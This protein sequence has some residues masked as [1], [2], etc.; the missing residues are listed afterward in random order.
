MWKEW[1]QIP[2][3]LN[4]NG[5]VFYPQEEAYKGTEQL[6]QGAETH[7]HL[8]QFEK[9]RSIKYVKHKQHKNKWHLIKH[10]RLGRKALQLE[11]RKEQIR[12]KEKACFYESEH[13][14]QTRETENNLCNLSGL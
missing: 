3:L 13:T 1:S 10:K 2:A 6:C 5:S 11:D 7:K 14:G 9:D 8:Q 12:L 4:N